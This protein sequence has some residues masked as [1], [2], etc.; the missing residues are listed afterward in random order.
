MTRNHIKHL[1]RMYPQ[2]QRVE[3]RGDGNR[4]IEGKNVRSQ[5]SMGMPRF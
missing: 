5:E 4:E 1:S 3:T 2:T